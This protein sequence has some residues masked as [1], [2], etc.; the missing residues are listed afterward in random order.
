M[1]H[2]TRIKIDLLFSYSSIKIRL[3]KLSQN[4]LLPM[5]KEIL[6]DPEVRILQ[7]EPRLFQKNY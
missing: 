2:E 4:Q 1:K 5:K 7:S 3:E 6:G